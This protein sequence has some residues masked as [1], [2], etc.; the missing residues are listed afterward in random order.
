M[1]RPVIPYGRQDIS[2][3]DIE[4][5]EAVLKSDFLTTGPCVPAFEAAI[6]AETGAAYAVAVNSAT[7]ALHIA[8]LALELGAGDW[9]W[10]SP[11]SFVASSNC[12]LYC[13]A[14]VDFVDV[15]PKTW[16]LC[17]DTLA[18][19]LEATPKDRMPKVVVPVAFGGRSADLIKMRALADQYGFA[20]LEDA[21]HAIGGTYDG[22]SVGDGR[23]ADITVF[24]FHPVKIVTTAEGG[25]AVTN[26]AG[27]AERMG[28]FR[29][30]GVTRDATLLREENP[31]PWYYEQLALG[32]NYRMT[33][34][35][36]ALGVSQMTR[37]EPFIARRRELVARY[38]ARLAALPVQRP[39]GDAGGSLSAWHLYP[40]MVD[41]AIR[42]QVFDGMRAAG[43]LV[44]VHYIP[45]HTQPYYRDLGFAAGDFPEAERYYAG[46]IS[47]PMFPA[48]SDADQDHVIDT[49]AGLLREPAA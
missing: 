46:A 40:V 23:Y 25:A 21:S 3:E 10:T 12:G 17:A 16:N 38:D 2:P 44:N 36:G 41:P 26:D 28:L 1:T 13:G 27:L 20:I 7:S 47:L 22:A 11:N 19:K 30:H 39:V 14:Q 45:I 8:C 6:K 5:V 4:A 18:A 34:M 15:D 24:S 9:L 31:D 37:L 49:L 42:R 43:V 33:D 48:L 29:S 35:Q 32:L